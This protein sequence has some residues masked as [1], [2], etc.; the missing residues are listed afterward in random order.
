MKTAAEVWD[1]A[2]V[3]AKEISDMF[4]APIELEFEQEIYDFFFILS[5]KRYMYRK[6]Y[7]DGVVHDEIGK[8]GVLLARRDN[9]KFIRDVYE[10]VI[11]R[12]ADNVD[13]PSIINYVVDQI[14]SLFAREKPIKDF[15]MTKAVGL[16]N[17]DDDGKMLV[18]KQ[19]A[20]E[21]GIMKAKIGTYSVTY[22]SKDLEKR[23]EELDK[24]GVDNENDFYVSSLPAVQQL[25]EKMRQ[26]GS[27][28]DVGSRI[29]YLISNEWNH[30]A[31]Q[32]EK[33]ESFE[34]YSEHSEIIRIDLLWY[35][36][37]LANPLDQLLNIGSSLSEEDFV[38]KQYTFRL[39]NRAKV[40][41]Q[42]KDL[43]VTKITF[44]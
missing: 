20:N 27:R 38:L 31:K 37:N 6:C 7:R 12:I 35:L 8:K 41:K 21:K 5:K 13:R 44:E 36:K 25:A 10:G 15:V 14:N 1:H 22:L 16:V 32:G 39:K 2:I 43:F 42:L 9:S 23:A 18:E 24:K 28:V 30:T 11:N 19:P 40:M 34:Y 17:V 4:P 29:E 26:R 3:V 33:V